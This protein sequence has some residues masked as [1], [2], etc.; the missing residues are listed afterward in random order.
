MP[1]PGAF[2]VGEEEKQAIAEV[3]ESQYLFRFGDVNNPKFLQKTAAL[4]RAAERAF[5]CKYALATTSGTASLLSSLFAVGIKP[6]DEVIVPAYT[7][8]ATYTAVIFLGGIPVLAEVDDSLT[9]DPE[10]IKKKI[11]PKTKAILPVHMLGNLCQMDAILDIAKEHGL[12]VVEDSCQAVGATYRGKSAG[13]IGDVGAM[14]LNFFKTITTGE[15]GMVVTDN[16]EYYERAFEFHHQGT[17]SEREGTKNLGVIGINFR[18]NEVT[19]A[20]ALA[21]LAKLPTLVERLHY[22]KDKFKGY[23]SQIPGLK[24]RTLN[25]DRG[26]SA[27][28]CVVVL[29]SAEE[30]KKIGALLGTGPIQESG[31][32][33]YSNMDHIN[34]FLKEHGQPYGYGAYPRTDD[35]MARTIALSVGVV[36]AGLGAGFGVNVLSSDEEIEAK[37]RQFE[38]AY[39]KVKSEQ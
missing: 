19:A 9:I 22:V 27:A 2:W 10:E 31:W 3:L 4:E 6:G 21:Q 1:G 35:L 18:S 16:P 33:V 38:E 30:T 26:E 11:T 39:R 34:A 14:S 25:D 15:G 37:A 24:F 32:H 23:L 17:P 12:A 8:L 36:D 29:D 20:F 13:T 7:Y 28:V 5:N